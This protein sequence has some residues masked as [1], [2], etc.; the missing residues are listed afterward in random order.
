MELYN[1]KYVYF[2]WDDELEGKKGFVADDVYV[3]KRNVE[4]N[5]EEWYGEI[6]RQTIH[7]NQNYPFEFIPDDSDDSSFFRFCYYDPDYEVKR[8]F[9]DGK[10]IQAHFKDNPH[11]EWFD[12]NKDT[13]SDRYSLE[14]FDLRMNEEWNVYVKMCNN[15]PAF[16]VT[17]DDCDTHC[18]FRGTYDNCRMYCDERKDYLRMMYAWEHGEK[19]QYF[20]DEVWKDVEGEPAFDKYEYRIKP[21]K[22]YA[23]YGSNCIYKDTEVNDETKSKVLACSISERIIDNFIKDH[24]Y[25]YDILKAGFSGEIIE[26]RKLYDDSPWLPWKIYDDTKLS[27]YDFVNYEYRIKPKEYVPFDTVQELIDYWDEKHPSNRPAD[28]LPLIWIKSKKK[29]YKYLITEFYFDKYRGVDVGTSHEEF[30]LRELFEDYT[31]L[32]GATIGKVK[33]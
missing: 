2:E 11:E 33:E 24:E 4:E 13:L 27:N 18:Y 21:T 29:D 28:T 10:T 1:K 32:Y 14:D 20:D 22:Y 31:F 3:L 6:C 8:A 16:N 5:R 7:T 15:I 19:L 17:Q 30:S 26:Y 25:L 9:F 23:I 12:I